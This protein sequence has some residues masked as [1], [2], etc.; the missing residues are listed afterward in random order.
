MPDKKIYSIRKVQSLVERLK[1]V[2]KTYRNVTTESRSISELARQIEDSEITFPPFYQRWYVASKQWKSQ[3]VASTFIRLT[4]GFDKIH[5][6]HTV[7]N[8]YEGLDGC[9]RMRSIHEFIYKNLKLPTKC[10]IVHTFKRNSFKFDLGGKT[11]K[12]IKLL[13]ESYKMHGMVDEYEGLSD[14][15]EHWKLKQFDCSIYSGISDYEAAEIFRILNDRTELEH[16]EKRNA[17]QSAISYFCREI[18]RDDNAPDVIPIG[19]ENRSYKTHP[20]FERLCVDGKWKSEGKWISMSSNKMAYEESAAEMVAYQYV[21]N[22]DT[23]NIERSYLDRLYLNE[24]F[25]KKIPTKIRVRVELI[26]D[27]MHKI[28]KYNTNIPSNQ[29]YSHPLKMFCVYYFIDWMLDNYKSFKMEDYK[30]FAIWFTTLH[31]KFKEDDI[32]RGEKVESR[33]SKERTRTNNKLTN[34]WLLNLYLNEFNQ[35]EDKRSIGVIKLDPKRSIRDAETKNSLLI[36]A[37][38]T[39]I[40]SNDDLTTKHM[41]SGHKF[42]AYSEGGPTVKANMYAISELTNRKQGIK[43]FGK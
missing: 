12:D 11:Y 43:P 36:E 4:K 37:K 19:K 38:Y 32:I 24:D 16:Q 31:E 10:S 27:Y 30:K 7:T 14:L 18:A 3:F 21:K 9:Q 28:A 34:T 33:Y 35:I 29:F 6:R 23:Y 2:T 40:D 42:K 1:I 13:I 20:L 17:I 5:L 22:N 26:C 15:M 25:Q 39:D 41:N 8:E